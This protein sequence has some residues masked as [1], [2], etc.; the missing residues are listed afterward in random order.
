MKDLRAAFREK[1]HSSSD[2]GSLVRTQH[3]DQRVRSRHLN[4]EARLLFAVLEDAI[5]C[6]VQFESSPDPEKRREIR[7]ALRWI[8]V[9]GDHDLFSFDSICEVFE[10]EP[11]SLRRQLNSMSNPDLGTKRFGS[12]GR[13]SV[14]RVPH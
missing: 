14:I 2:Y 9:R 13:R 6:I 3:Y 11:E 4:G 10:I 8:N 5:R 7:E 1:S 12:V